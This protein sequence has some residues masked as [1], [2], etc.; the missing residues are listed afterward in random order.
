VDE[1]E[2]LARL[3][4]GAG[5]QRWRRLAG[6]RGGGQTL[7]GWRRRRARWGGGDGAAAGGERVD[8]TEG[9][10]AAEEHGRARVRRS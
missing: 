8:E 5:E 4:V 10:R 3:L 7:G 9:R 2:S 6:I 1:D